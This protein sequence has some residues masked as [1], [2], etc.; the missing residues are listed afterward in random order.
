MT[1]GE[2]GAAAEVIRANCNLL[3]L[4]LSM[5]FAPFGANLKRALSWQEPSSR[6]MTGQPSAQ[7]SCNEPLDLCPLWSL[8]G[9]VHPLSLPQSAPGCTSEVSSLG[10]CLLASPFIACSM[11]L[12]AL[13]MQIITH[14]QGYN[15]ESFTSLDDSPD[16]F[17]VTL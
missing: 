5:L 13:N 6:G 9:L 10:G 7:L 17:P 3:K 1:P 8:P 14:V 12:S 16:D 4:K 15:L 2:A 11:R